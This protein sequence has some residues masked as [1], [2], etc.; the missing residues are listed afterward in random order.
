MGT[1]CAE[2]LWEPCGS[3]SDPWSL[4]KSGCSTWLCA[5]IPY[6]VAGCAEGSAARLSTGAFA[7]R[8]GIKVV[9]R[10]LCVEVVDLTVQ[11]G[12]P[13]EVVH[14]VLRRKVAQKAFCITSCARDFPSEFLPGVIH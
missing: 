6:A 7:A 1:V 11:R 2:L 13:S 9:H 8:L 10:G 3:L 14:Q 5:R 12:C 4:E